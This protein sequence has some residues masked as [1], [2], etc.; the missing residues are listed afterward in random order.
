MMGD[1]STPPGGYSDLD[2][3]GGW[4]QTQWTDAVNPSQY[5]QGF[6]GPRPACTFADRK[7]AA[8]WF[9]AAARLQHHRS[10]DIARSGG[11]ANLRHLFYNKFRTDKDRDPRKKVETSDSSSSVPSLWPS[12]QWTPDYIKPPKQ[13]SHLNDPRIKRKD[14]Y[15]QHYKAISGLSEQVAAS[16]TVE[17]RPAQPALPTAI[18]DS[19]LGSSVH[20]NRDNN[21]RPSVSSTADLASTLTSNVLNSPSTGPV[22]DKNA[23]NVRQKLLDVWQQKRDQA[24][25]LSQ[26]TPLEEPAVFSAPSSRSSSP[27]TSTS[28]GSRAATPLTLDDIPDVP[29][30]KEVVKTAKISASSNFA[31]IPELPTFGGERSKV[32]KSMETTKVARTMETAKVAKV[33]EFPPV[34]EIGDTTAGVPSLVVVNKA[35]VRGEFCEDFSRSFEEEV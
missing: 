7:T 14:P 23:N 22:E 17:A 18:L 6:D 31:G 20:Q 8:S 4:E 26:E 2:S 32:A 3:S 25:A 9:Q 15:E 11:T 28:A 24:R 12:Q 35:P 29:V 16:C 5:E 21:N 1:Y 13:P 33:A 10:A 34:S 30:E 19:I 27:T